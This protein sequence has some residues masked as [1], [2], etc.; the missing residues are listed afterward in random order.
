[1]GAY[2]ST[3]I[4]IYIEIPHIKTERKETKFKNAINARR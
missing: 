3:Y 1:M 2:N 4:G